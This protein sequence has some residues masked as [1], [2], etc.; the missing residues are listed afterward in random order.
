MYW[1]KK[2]SKRHVKNL[3]LFFMMSVVILLPQINQHAMILGD[4]SLFHLNRFYDTAMQLKDHNLQYFISMY[5]YFGSGRIVNALYGPGIAYL[6]GALLLIGGSWFKYQLLSDLFV[7]MLAAISMYYLVNR[8]KIAQSLQPWLVILYMSSNGVL[9]WATDQQFLGWGTAILP[10]GIA[11]I[12]RLLQD[13]E[14]VNILEMAFSVAIMVQMHMLTAV[15]YVAVLAV[16]FLIRMVQSSQRWSMVRSAS[17]A[18]VFALGLTAN[19]WLGM[20]EVFGSNHVLSPTTQVT[21]M[22]HVLLINSNNYLSGLFKIIFGLQLG[23]VGLFF[24]KI[25]RVNRWVT[26]TGGILLLMTMPFLPWNWLFNH[27]PGLSIIQFPFRFLPF[28]TALLIIGFGLSLTQIMAEIRTNGQGKWP[29]NHRLVPFFLTGLATVAVLVAANQVYDASQ[30]W[31]EGTVVKTR[32]NVKQEVSN[33]QLK[34][35]FSNLYPLNTA[36]ENVW[37]PTPDYVPL[38]SGKIPAHPYYEY[39]LEIGDTRHAFTRTIRNGKMYVTWQQ[40]KAGWQAV[41]VVKYAHTQLVLNKQSL[42]NKDIKLSDIGVVRVYGQAG[43][44]VLQV[45]YQPQ[46]FMRWGFIVLIVSWIS[47]LGLAIYRHWKR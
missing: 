11:V 43:K 14:P 39:Q 33:E 23:F 9:A 26:V 22:D 47:W 46:P 28:A 30:S 13:D 5:G 31:S 4:D 20:L 27:V 18:A 15:I 29:S 37:K 35:S 12:I 24:H 40:K 34:E 19:I 44:N 45:Q 38:P 32:V 6:N 21:P 17:L 3:V 41:N 42:S 1:R 36:L 16:I 8:A 10:I 2:L 25:S 7:S